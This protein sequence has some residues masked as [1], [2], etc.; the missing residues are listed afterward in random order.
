[1]LSMSGE[2]ADN[3]SKAAEQ[4]L[5]LETIMAS[6]SRKIEALRDPYNNYNKLSLEEWQQQ[7]PN[8][9]WS[10]YITNLT[11]KKIDSV[12]VGQPEFFTTLN[13]L[14]DSIP[15]DD[16]KAYVKF[17]LISD[18]AALLPDRFGQASFEFNRLFSGAKVR[19]PRWTRMIQLQEGAMGEL[20]GQLY[21]K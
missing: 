4:I 2:N 18:M 21:V 13:T 11:G 14:L 10:A 8:I 12:I 17:N 1:M 20:M 16:F 5:S 6:A 9:N 19:K 15:M 3:A 7:T